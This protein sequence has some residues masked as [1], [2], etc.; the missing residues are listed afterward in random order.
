MR[1]TQAD[2]YSGL[3][4]DLGGED[5]KKLLES[6]REKGQLLPVAVN[7][8]GIL[9]DGHQRAR[10]CK[11][12]SIEPHFNVFTFANEEEEL[13]FVVASNL[14][15]RHLNDVQKYELAKKLLPMEAEFARERQ[16]RGIKIDAEEKG[17]SLKKIGRDIGITE[18]KLVRMKALDDAGRSD[19]LAEIERG[20]TTVY[21]AYGR[22]IPK[23]LLKDDYVVPPFSVL[24]LRTKD[25]LN[26][27][28]VYHNRFDSGLGRDQQGLGM[29]GIVA[30]GMRGVS[31]FHPLVCRFGYE[32]YTKEGDMVLDPFCGGSVRG[33][34][35]G[36]LGRGYVGFDLRQE[37]IDEN[38][39][40]AAKVEWT[41]GK[42][43]P[44]WIVSDSVNLDR[45]LP[46][47]FEANL[48]FTSPPYSL[49]LE[50][51][52][53]KPEDLNN[54]SLEGFKEKYAEIIRKSLK[55]LKKDG[56][57]MWTVSD[58]RDKN[59]FY[60]QLDAYTTKIHEEM[61]WGLWNTIIELD[62]LGTAPQR[63]RGLFDANKKVVR[64]H[65]CILIYKHRG[66]E[67]YNL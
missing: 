37:Q 62:P 43:K 30:V 3:F 57:S 25:A 2:K 31:V 35:A 59:G 50:H 11:E 47:D 24:D 52:S 9:L 55:Y 34:M 56:F 19:L 4:P 22:V 12:L 53:D 1:I 5:Y 6:I 65:Q 20:N 33:I 64:V 21:G 67:L 40:Q 41:D 51:Y 38:E 63:A 48:V 54:M 36:E 66:G 26:S 42:I 60:W 44:K 39:E 61:G 27:K 16:K 8:D 28:A 18:A 13:A 7:K 49:G 58:A 15:R 23:V 10:V 32:N 17:T 46:T 29:A 45:N 14:T